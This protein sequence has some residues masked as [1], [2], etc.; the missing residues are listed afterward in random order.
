MNTSSKSLKMAL[1]A[2]CL[3]STAPAAFAQ[4]FD[5]VR[6]FGAAPTEGRGTVGL[7]AIFGHEYQGSD[8]RR[9]MAVPL[10]DYRWANGWFA[11]TS[12]GIGYDFSSNPYMNYGLR[13]TADLGRKENRSAALKGM[14]DIDAKAE[15]GGFFN[16]AVSPDMVL[17]S[18]L[19]YGSGNA[20]K[21]LLLDL[22]AAYSTTLSPGWRLGLGVAATYINADAMQGNFGVDAAQSARSGYAVYAPKAGI[23]DVRASASLTYQLSARM[24]ITTAVSASSLQG[25]AKHSPLTREANGVSGVLALSYG[26]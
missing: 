25:D 12:N 13:L 21:N 24:A 19:R 4:A 1:L 11:G 5:A 3:T 8:E 10:L 17:T 2:A 26:F 7:A 22:G 6:L 15:V 16:Y 23:R 18:S 20:K 9:T 14:G